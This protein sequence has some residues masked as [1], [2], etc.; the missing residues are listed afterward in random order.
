MTA[1][2]LAVAFVVISCKSKLGE[3]EKL[4]LQDAPLQTVE[5]MF[6]V[7]SENGHPKMRIE[8]S[9]MQ[10]FENDTCTYEYFPEGFAVYTYL[11]DGKVES[12]IVSDKAKHITSKKAGNPETWQAFGNVVI[13][14]IIKGE[15]IVTD[16]LYWD[17]GKHEIYT[18]CY[19]RMDSPQGLMQGYGLRSDD[20]ARNSILHKPFDSFG[21]TKQ[22]T[23]KIVV[24]SVNFI[25]PFEKK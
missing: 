11:P 6:A 1:T 9:L 24:D 13:R 12:R 17:Q 14:N 7:D 5:N 19:V 15:T 10:R 20:R 23:T 21:V 18:D 4:S 3:A 2:A 16:T 25:G 22:D 8:A